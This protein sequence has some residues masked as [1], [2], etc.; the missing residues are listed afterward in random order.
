MSPLTE[1][2]KTL[3]LLG[4]MWSAACLTLIL[5]CLCSTARAAAPEPP[6]RPTPVGWEQWQ[7]EQDSSDP[8]LER[9]CLTVWAEEIALSD[10]LGRVAEA[11]GVALTAE[12]DLL[13]TRLTVF[14]EDCTPA[15][16]MVALAGVVKGYWL[17]PRKQVGQARTYRL[18][19][20]ALPG[21]A[22]SEWD[23]LRLAARRELLEEDRKAWEARLDLYSQT[24]K[25]S[26]DELL[27]SYGES[28]PTLSADLRRRRARP[29][30]EHLC[31]LGEA[32][33]EELLS[34]GQYACPLRSFDPALRA[35][36]RRLLKARKAKR[37]PDKLLRFATPEERWDNAVVWFRRWGT[38][39]NFMLELPDVG[40]I[41]MF[42]IHLPRR[43][44]AGPLRQGFGPQR[45]PP[46]HEYEI[47]AEIMAETIAREL[48][49]E[50][51]RL[52]Q[53]MD[54]GA[55]AGSDPSVPGALE[56][57]SRQ[58]DLAVLAHCLPGEKRRLRP[59]ETESPE[60]QRVTLGTLLAGLRRGHPAWTWRFYGRY[61]TVRHTDY[62]N[63]EDC[64]I[65]DDLLAKL[66]A[67]LRPGASLSLE[68]AAAL[69][70]GLNTWQIGTLQEKLELYNTPLWLWRQYGLVN[71]AVDEKQREA[72]TSARG[73]P[74]TEL[75]TEL[76][77]EILGGAKTRRP[78]LE[79]G[80]FSSTTLR[81]IPRTFATGEEG[82]S[83]ILDYHFP[84]SPR[85][86]DVLL[87]SSLQVTVRGY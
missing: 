24:L 18:T 53:E 6:A 31:G 40:L 46:R 47:M 15:G 60:D 82:I 28:D 66:A 17:Y 77:K 12:P 79:W 35:E 19:P 68:E 62:A 29:M 2:E 63:I 65:P 76:Q 56:E 54:L 83:L 51:P 71:E 34:T 36:V 52:K 22:T 37:N 21:D 44:R 67:K 48:N 87:T 9:R 14:A 7:P 84:D 50:E 73:L 33:R 72:L 13:D 78:W 38:G 4:V 64:R 80:D 16:L 70:A 85:D 49:L 23:A 39:V 45:G 61:L 55:L 58:C 81:M 30:I 69:V 75:G 8:R 43:S 27:W 32:D 74:V 11:S 42:G 1:R 26:R 57:V 5:F 59:F 10:L 3:R 86:R 20:A 25:L 41:D